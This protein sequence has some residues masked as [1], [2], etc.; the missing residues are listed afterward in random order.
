MPALANQNGTVTP[1]RPARMTDHILSRALLSAGD[2]A[3][4]VD[5]A[6]RIVLWNIAAERLLGHE[7]HE[8]LG[9]SCCDVMGGH[10]PSGEAVCAMEC[11]LRRRASSGHPV[12]SMDLDTRTSAGQPVRIN[13]STIAVAASGHD[14]ALT[15]HLFRD[16]PAAAP[17]PV[18]ASAS[19]VAED[20][21]AA[22]RVASLTR[23]EREILKLLTTGANTRV[24]AQRLGVSQSTIRNH[25]QNL[26]GKLGVH[27][28]LQAVAF[29]NAH[30]VF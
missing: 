12:D 20:V 29:V 19:A 27:S 5:T 14:G 9:R 3:V 28:R 23:R 17:N 8:V 1:L 25:V 11:S 2:G 15:V 22:E 21:D 13:V 6:G 7:A 4:A 16:V 30:R 10:S 18:S 24:A 26:F